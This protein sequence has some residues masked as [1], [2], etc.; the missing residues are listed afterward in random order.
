[1]KN[2]VLFFFVTSLF[3]NIYSQDKN[4]NFEYYNSKLDSIISEYSISDHK[5]PHNLNISFTKANLNKIEREK[6]IEKIRMMFEQKRYPNL[7]LTAHILLY[8][9]WRITPV[10]NTVKIKQKLLEL[11]L[12]YYFY[13]GPREYLICSDYS[14]LSIKKD[15]TPKACRRIL[16]ILNGNKTEKEYDIYLA[17]KKALPTSYDKMSWDYAKIEMRKRKI[18]NDTILKEIRDSLLSDY[19]VY[20][21]K[22]S[23]E[24]EQIQ[25]DIILMAGFLGM[26][27]CIPTMQK[28]L[29]AEIAENN[30]YKGTEIAYRLA[31]AKLGD[32]EQY[33]YILDTIISTEYFTKNFLSYFRDVT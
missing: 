12:Q 6:I 18:Q 25:P 11:Y 17:Y 22:E 30:Y 33:Q 3:G 26:K 5:Y 31:L 27:E 28:N 2:I 13:P 29:Q 23:L 15:Y 24:L 1:M 21:A 20:S 10:T 32:K 19:I 4:L 16:E 9:I 7:Y 8:A 14:D